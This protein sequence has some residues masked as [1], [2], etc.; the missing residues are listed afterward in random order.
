MP[1]SVVMAPSIPHAAI[2]GRKLQSLDGLRGVFF[3][4]QREWI[5]TLN[6]PILFAKT[7]LGLGWMG[8]DLFFVLS[9]FLI[10]GILLDTREASNYFSGFYARRSLRILQAAC[11]FGS[12][13]A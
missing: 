2:S 11:C 9:G 13:S 10:T 3:H 1:Q 7:Y 8:V 6:V 5:P 12:R 4:H